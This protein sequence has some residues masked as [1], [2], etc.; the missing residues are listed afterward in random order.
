VH[1]QSVSVGYGVYGQSAMGNGVYGTT[2]DTSGA[3]SGVFAN[4]TGSNYGAGVYG[5]DSTTGLESET[6]MGW[7]YNGA[8]VWGDGGADW[9]TGEGN[10][11]VVGTADDHPGGQFENNSA[12]YSTLWAFNYNEEGY[13]F[14]AYN[15]QGINGSYG[16]NIDPNGDINCTGLKNAVVPIDGGQRTVALSAIESPKSWFEDFGSSQ[17]SNGSAVVT[18]DP[19]Y[20]QTVNTELEYHVFLTPN[21]DCKGLYISQRTPA[22]FEVREL[23]G[24]TSSIE[25]SY[26]IV[27]LRKNYENIRMAD[28]T[29]DL[30]AMKKMMA[31]KG[32][33]TPFRFETSKMKVPEMPAPS[34]LHQ[35]P[36][37]HNPVQPPAPQMPRPVQ[38]PV[39]APK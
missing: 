37:M 21:G 1:G 5:Q 15:D 35:P 27:A 39:Q 3:F 8:G 11:G 24:G 28:H 38:A 19:E 32:S 17:L 29:H 33:G 36:Q 22:S 25:F 9:T 7:S 14:G 2:G 23:G 4:D 20:G 30:D 31:K 6:G 12:S 26:R 13:P 10:F 16:C 34:A 18:I